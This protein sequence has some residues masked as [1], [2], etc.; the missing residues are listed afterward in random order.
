MNL[1]SLQYPIGKFQKPDVISQHTIDAWITEIE[2]LPVRLRELC[3]TLSE[4]QL[5][6]TYRPG[7]WI[8]R[9]VIHH[10]A[11]S[12]MN[13]YIRLKLAVTEENPT[14]RP[15]FED[16]W[17]ECEDGKHADVSLSLNLLEA[18]HKRLVLFIRSLKPD[19]LNRTYFHPESQKTF[20]LKEV[21]GIYAWHG[22]H[23]LKHVR[24]TLN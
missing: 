1:E 22:N 2:S 11:D 17:A 12:H 24:S 9:Q 13:A 19:E 10:L 20:V 15:Y 6:T 14:I 8:V 18:L 5:E 3:A 23:H 7:G 4:V 21:I 16:R